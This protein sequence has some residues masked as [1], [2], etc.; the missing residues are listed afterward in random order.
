MINHMYDIL[1]EQW[2][3]AVDCQWFNETLSLLERNFLGK[4]V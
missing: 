1:V 2:Y 4:Q 3:V